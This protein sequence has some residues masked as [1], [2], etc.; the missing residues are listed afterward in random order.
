MRAAD[1]DEQAPVHSAAAA[2]AIRRLP[3]RGYGRTEESNLFPETAGTWGDFG[4]LKSCSGLDNERVRELYFR[5][6]TACHGA[7]S[8]LGA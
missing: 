7:G 4:D 8:H 3:A 2:N 5:I 6:G 1:C